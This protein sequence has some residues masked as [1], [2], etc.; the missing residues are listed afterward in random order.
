[1][2]EKCSK[3]VAGFLALSGVLFSAV[4]TLANIPGG[5]TGTGSNVTV[6][7]NGNGTVTMANGVLSILIT[8]NGATVNQM[9]YTFNNGSGTQTL[10][11][12]AGGKNGGQFYWEFG[13]WGGSSWAY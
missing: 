3:F 13:G 5:G 6:T 10:Q 9:N 4:S 1:M 11:L 2:F 7:D 8:K 12:L